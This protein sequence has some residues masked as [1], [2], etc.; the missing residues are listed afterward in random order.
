[1]R[2]FFKSRRLRMLALVLAVTVA[3]SVVSGVVGKWLDPQATAVGALLTP[4][5]K[6]TTWLGNGVSDFILAHQRAEELAQE[7]AE[8]REDLQTV[9]E[10]LIDFE[11]YQRE[12]EYLKQFLEIKQNHEDYTFSNGRVISIDSTD[13]Y[14]SY[15]VDRGT[16]DGVAL[17][18]PVMT[19][20][21]LLG[22]ISEI[23]ATSCVVMTVL[24]PSMSVGA[25]C[26]RTGDYGVVSGLATLASGGECRLDYLS[27]ETGL[28]PGDYI[29]TS[30]LGGVFPEGLVIGTVKTV[31]RDS[32]TINSYAI[33]A[34]T[35]EFDEVRD[36]M[37]LTGFSGQKEVNP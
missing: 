32:A 14:L 5:Q 19:A 27:P 11:S 21:G 8:L 26:A 18:D 6:L 23:S 9:T 13:G 7:N 2:D 37:I 36:V 1:M 24:N 10:Q 16:L 12:N 25:Y 29:I 4:V 20:D 22:Y 28:S 35:V 34:S 33:V 3:V 15:T 17:H 30:G 31:A